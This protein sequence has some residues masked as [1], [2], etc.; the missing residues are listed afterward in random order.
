[1]AKDDYHVI[2][3][4]ILAYL[5]T[6]LKNGDAVD[7]DLL[8]HDSPYMGINE[9]YWQYIILNM[10]EQGYVK[11]ITAKKAWGESVIISDLGNAQITPVGIEFLCDNS[12]LEKA[13]QFLKDTKA[14]VPFI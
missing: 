11:G 9:T 14:I 10:L 5:Y 8:K 1:M 4:Q 13:K 6:Q 12:F 3:Y 7:G 2:V